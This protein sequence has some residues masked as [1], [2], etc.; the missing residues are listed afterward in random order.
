MTDSGFK[1][2][3]FKQVM[4]HLEDLDLTNPKVIKPVR[5]ALKDPFYQMRKTSR[6][7][8]ES[9]GSIDTK[10]LYEGLSVGSKFSKTKGYLTVAYG[11]RRR[12]NHKK[13]RGAIGSHFH[14]VNSGT[15][16]RWRKNWQ[17]T[18]K[19]G[20]RRTVRDNMNKSFRLGFADKAIR[21][22]LNGLGSYYT[23]SFQKVFD[24]IKTAGV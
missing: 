22:R 4:K 12:P 18:G 13:N 8:L 6:Q 14:L 17:Y 19:V 15:K 11:G 24:D 10:N 5:K 9:Q 3:N 21:A 7:N 20:K 16:G 2:T 1:I 23:K